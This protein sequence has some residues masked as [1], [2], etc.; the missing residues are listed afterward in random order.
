MRGVAARLAE[1]EAMKPT[2]LKEEWRKVHGQDPPPV[3]ASL[4]ARALAY[5]VQCSAQGGAGQR[6][7]RRLMGAGGG[8]A[9]APRVLPPGT[10]LVR[11]WG[12]ES[13]HVLMEE[14]GRCAYRG[15]SFASL[16]AVARH[17][18]GAHWSGPRFF[19]GKP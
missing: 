13:H 1:I 10:Q 5:D 9:V 18:T 6:M 19:G 8:R 11:E 14:M 4:L 12:G 2:A 3:T 16:S 17:I 7:R 15:K